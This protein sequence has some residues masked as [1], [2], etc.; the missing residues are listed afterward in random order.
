[1]DATIMM[2]FLGELSEISTKITLSYYRTGRFSVETKKDDSPV[3]I[4]DRNT[5]EALRE[6]IL[7]RF[8]DHG[9]IG[10]EFPNVAEDA[11]F[12]WVLDPIDGTKSF[13]AGCPLFGTLVALRKGTEPIWGM[14]HL[15]ALG[16]TYI[17]DNQTA[18]CN[19]KVT[20]IRET[21]S[22]ENCLLLFTDPKRGAGPFNWDNWR[23]LM[24]T[25]GEARGWGDCFGYTLVASGGAD[26]MCDPIMSL[27]DLAALI[28]VVRGA[29][30]QV[31]D[32]T[33]ANPATGSS[34]VV[35][36]PRHHAAVLEILNR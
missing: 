17:G 1:M 30:A 32:W 5:E 25:C 2:P 33:G 26:L 36:H 4:A 16:L 8:P 20:T 18:W 31:T 21:P 28:P 14:I 24:D 23:T 13:V 3:T 35:A 6:A 10:E 7:S 15:P 29:G 34:L 11:E 9:I 19:D 12:S 27:W 22:L